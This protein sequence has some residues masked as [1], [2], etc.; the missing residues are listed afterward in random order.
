MIF[1][2]SIKSRI[3]IAGKTNHTWNHISVYIFGK[4]IFTIPSK[5][6]KVLLKQHISVFFTVTSLETGYPS[7]VN[8][9]AFKIEPTPNGTESFKYV[10]FL[11]SYTL[12]IRIKGSWMYFCIIFLY[13]LHVFTQALGLTCWK[14]CEGSS[15]FRIEALFWRFWHQVWQ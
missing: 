3:I 13:K 5:K 9:L 14:S 7:K 4:I 1:H 10:W 2:F 15:R 6:E 8:P 12:E 11:A